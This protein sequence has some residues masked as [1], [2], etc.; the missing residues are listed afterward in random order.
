MAAPDAA[1][2]TGAGASDGGTAD[3]KPKPAKAS[4]TGSPVGRASPRP[5]STKRPEAGVEHRIKRNRA[6]STETVDDD[7]ATSEAPAFRS[8]AR[9][10]MNNGRPTQTASV[11][12]CPVAVSESLATASVVDSFDSS[13]LPSPASW[14][15][16]AV[17]AATISCSPALPRSVGSI[18]SRPGC[19]AGGL[20]ADN[21]ASPVAS[22]EKTATTGF[23]EA[24]ACSRLKE[25]D[26][27][28]AAPP[29]ASTVVPTPMTL[30][31]APVAGAKLASSS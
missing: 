27:A 9:A 15:N 18:S 4:D 17:N 24:S 28:M 22:P 5:P 13:G 23:P 1:P 29:S 25:N 30:A 3:T 8:A 31:A 6:A 7:V 2:A 26:F 21:P 19:A 10:S 16:P 11:S 20:M 14:V 12:I